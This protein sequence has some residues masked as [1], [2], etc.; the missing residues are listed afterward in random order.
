MK[1]E[2]IIR[3]YPKI[4][5]VFPDAYLDKKLNFLFFPNVPLPPKFNL[6]KT[7]LLL[8]LNPKLDYQ[9]PDAYVDKNLE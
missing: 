7:P 4:K 2:I 9:V 3:D 1:P 6:P 5:K 8:I